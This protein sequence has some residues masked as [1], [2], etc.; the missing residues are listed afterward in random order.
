M[1]ARLSAPW[2]GT[3]LGVLLLLVAWTLAASLGT[4]SMILPTPASTVTEVFSHLGDYFLPTL[5]STLERALWGYLW[6]NLAGLAIA[7]LVLL[8]PA[9]ENLFTQLGVISQCL[10]ITA[11]GPL[12]LLV[13]GGR[14]AAIFL[15]A[16]LVFFTTMVGAILGMRSASATALDLVRAY[17]GGRFTRIRKVQLIAAL[18]SVFTALKVAVP[19]A[20]L[21]G[22]VGEY[23]GGTDDGVGVALIVA[24]RDHNPQ[25]VWGLSIMIGLVALAGYALI[26]LLGRVLTPWAGHG[27]SAPAG[28][29]A[30]AARHGVARLVLGRFALTALAAAVAIVAWWAVLRIFDVSDLIGQRP[31]QVWA[32]LFTEDEAAANRSELLGYLYQ[33]LRD[34]GVGY[35]IGLGVAFVLAVL[36]S[37][38]IL[39]ENVLTPTAMVFRMIPIVVITPLVTLIFGV[40]VGGVTAIVTLSVFLPALANILFGLREAQNRH[41]DLIHAF[42]GNKGQL[43]LKVALPGAL[44]AL[45]ASARISVPA[46]VTGAMI[47][48]WLATGDGLGGFISRSAGAFG[49]DAMY[50]SAAVIAAVTMLFYTVISIVDSLVERRFGAAA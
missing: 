9:V 18:P 33:T 48:E 4:T 34:C 43:L 7:A 3:V 38:S 19:A 36:F 22:V 17:G 16:L 45:F 14:A 44:P 47:G 6:G 42:G 35:A 5:W 41:G 29:G 32:Y 46:A 27:S 50:A 37:L 26:G 13:F 24:Q 30:G 11:I 39:V 20:V 10:P 40:G 23:L 2:V 15:A 49:Y 31:D 8:I 12:V 25:R 28:P 1:N 21:G